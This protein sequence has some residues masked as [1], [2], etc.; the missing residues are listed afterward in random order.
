MNTG[1]G[2]SV[3][4]LSFAIV[5][6]SGCKN[7]PFCEPLGAC[8]G[9]VLAGAKDFY[10]NDGLIDRSWAVIAGGACQDQLQLPP[11]PVS[12][13]RQPPVVANQRPPDNVTADWCGNVLF[14]PTGEVKEFLY[15]APPLPLKVGQLTISADYDG[16]TTRG[17]YVMQTTIDQTRDLVLSES[18]LTQQ[19]LHL[20]CPVLG[21]RLGDFLRTEA[22]FY[23][24][25]CQDPPDPHQGGCVCKFD[26]SFIGGP[27]GRWALQENKT[28]I[29]FFDM[30]L[31][32]PALAD[33]CFRP[34][35]TRQD[36]SGILDLTGS[37]ETPLFNQK[38]L[39]TMHMVPPSCTDGVQSLDLGETGI[40]CGGECPPCGSCLNGS[41]APGCACQN[42]V[43]D[44]NEEG[45]DCG[46]ACLGI[47]CDPDP[48]ITAPT[49]R[50]AA[51]ANGK[52]DPWEEGKDCG[53]PCPVCGGA[54]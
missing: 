26:E 43:H 53:G 52:Q 1:L 4:F 2:K 22:N 39:R 10:L 46:G 40:D 27:S 36:M 38:G 15:Y 19:G 20:A 34:D 32:P 11:L 41:T 28:Q 35:S 6:V 24:V 47:L 31:T 42:G 48:T 9:D 7:P 51:C 49:Q 18:C 5:A 17:T 50:H 25:R 44:A 8:G 45:I 3:L 54:P 29:E 33:F 23:N 16:N 37:N 13:V 30:L 21:R 12:L 14:K